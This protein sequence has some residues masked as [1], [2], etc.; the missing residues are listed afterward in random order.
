MNAI[1]LT[2]AAALAV[3]YS[4]GF[5]LLMQRSLMR[6][7][8]ADAGA[9]GIPELIVFNKSDLIASDDRLVLRGLEPGAVFASA[10][11]GD[12]IPELLA[13]IERLL[14]DPAVE[15]DVVVPYHR[16]D[17]VSIMHQNGRVL[18]QEHVAEGTRV[19]ALVN[20]DLAGRLAKYQLPSAV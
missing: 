2:M 7:L 11:T 14:P 19:H 4:V 16:G 20:P 10:R 18:S 8:L 9:R 17:L 15:I 5:F 13:A 12:G 6:V 3:L 1:N